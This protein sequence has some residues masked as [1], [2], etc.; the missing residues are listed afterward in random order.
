MDF[1][2]LKQS[3]SNFDKLTKAIEANLNSENK[4]KTNQNTKTTD[5]GNQN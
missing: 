3:S 1:D 4:E 5:F 2:T